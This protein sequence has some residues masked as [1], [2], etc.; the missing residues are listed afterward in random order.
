M[1]HEVILRCGILKQLWQADYRDLEFAFLDSASAKH[2]ARGSSPDAGRFR[3]G[4]E[5][6]ISYLKRCFG[7]HRCP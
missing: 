3:A 5:A 7:L 4:I 1:P 2:F 6:A